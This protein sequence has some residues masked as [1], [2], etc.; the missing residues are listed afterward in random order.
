MNNWLPIPYR[1][2]IIG[3]GISGLSAAHTVLKYSKI[4]CHIKI[5][6]AQSR[7][8]GWLESTRFDDGTVMEHGP[9]TGRSYGA[10]ALQALDILSEFDIDKHII[11]IPKTLPAAKRR[12]IYANNNICE[13]PSSMMSM[14]FRQQ[15]FSKSLMSTLIKEPFV[16]KSLGEDESVYDFFARRFNYE[17]ANYISDPLCKGIFG[18]DARKLSLQSCLPILFNYEQE[19]GSVIKGAFL[20]KNTKVEDESNIVKKAK[21]ENWMAWSLTNGMETLPELWSKYLKDLGVDILLNTHCNQLTFKNDN[22][23]QCTTNEGI[24]ECERV[25]STVPSYNLSPLIF[26]S[27]GK[28]S[29][30]LTSVNYVNMAVINLEYKN[31]QLP[32]EGFGVLVPSTEPCNILGITFDSLVIP[33]HSTNN[34]TIL[35]VMAG[36]A[37]F[38][39]LFGCPDIIDIDKINELAVKSVQ[40]ILRI[41]ETPSRIVCR[42]QKQCIPQYE[43]GHEQKIDSIINYVRSNNIPLTIVGNIFG[44]VGVNDVIVN[45]RNE[46]LKWLSMNHMY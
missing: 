25:I 41:K 39:D 38:N 29:E 33:Q 42:I 8:G 28:L 20:T 34:S 14:F 27:H 18:G 7:V 16:K 46:T 26:E 37:W 15:P 36:G 22:K 9:R 5:I 21:S 19:Y 2:I 17:I 13:L 45:S 30:L 1:V 6:E 43:I 40:D 31:I 32:V 23:I 11:G 3:S 10:V 35:T 12:F 44:G 4:P 24:Y